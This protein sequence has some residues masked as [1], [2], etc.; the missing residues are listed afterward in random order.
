MKH[1]TLIISALFTLSLALVIACGAQ[2]DSLSTESELIQQLMDD[3]MT[4]QIND[5][6]QK[7]LNLTLY[8][9]VDVDAMGEILKNEPEYDPCNVLADISDLKFAAEYFDNM[10]KHAQLIIAIKSKYPNAVNLDDKTWAKIFYNRETLTD[11]DVKK[12]IDARYKID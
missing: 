8:S 11:E 12:M 7:Q 9:D 2:S 6:Y 10:C 3:P 1:K 4:Q 5:V